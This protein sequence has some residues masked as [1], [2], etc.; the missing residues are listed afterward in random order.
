MIAAEFASPGYHQFCASSYAVVSEHALQCLHYSCHVHIVRI[1]HFGM[2]L[3][4]L[5]PT[6]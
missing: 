1:T 2:P 5:K 6:H 4:L 3:L